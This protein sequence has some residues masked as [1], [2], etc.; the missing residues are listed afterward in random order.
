MLNVSNK[1]EAT[2]KNLRLFLLAAFEPAPF[3]CKMQLIGLC[4]VLLDG[5]KS[6]RKRSL[7]KILWKSSNTCIMVFVQKI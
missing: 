1:L 2:R 6:S 3:K 5:K 4:P 7:I